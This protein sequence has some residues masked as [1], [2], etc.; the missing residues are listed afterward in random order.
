MPDKN[1]TYTACWVCDSTE[2][3]RIKDSDI[4]DDLSSRNF[5]IT[6]FDYGTTGELSRCNHC[7][8]IQ[9]TD[10]EDVVS[11]YED[12][13]DPEY[14]SGRKERLLQEQKVLSGI[15]KIKSGGSLLD[16]GAGSGMLVETAIQ[17]AYQAEGIEPSK[18]LQKI[19]LEHG[20][21]VHL[22]TFPH[23]NTPGP[24]DVITF[25][26]V[27]E[28]VNNPLELLTGLRKALK[29][30]G[31][32]VLV[33]PDVRSFPARMLKYRWWHYRIA[34]IGYFNQK[35]L[36]LLAG[37]AGLELIRM[38]R[39]TW[40]FTA[41]YLAVRTLLFFPKFL[42]FPVPRFM[43]NIIIPLNLRDSFLAFYKP[44]KNV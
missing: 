18:Y 33:T 41:R 26:D 4:R 19:A 16:V 43:D 36:S 37:R 2:L 25:I 13:E 27:L 24:Y 12:L 17:A 23:K 8:F 44:A 15:R 5:A 3:T 10:L 34:H 35:T 38:K 29:E 32:L 42:R 9:C 11:F 30:D 31:I 21:P 1:T 28:H 14:E 40:Y 20:L 7:G 22:G 39:P 6:N